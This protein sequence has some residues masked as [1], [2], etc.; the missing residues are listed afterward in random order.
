M[1]QKPAVAVYILVVGASIHRMQIAA[2]TSM[3]FRHAGY[4]HVK[5]NSCS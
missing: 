3:D 4:V 5:R 1:I 2:L